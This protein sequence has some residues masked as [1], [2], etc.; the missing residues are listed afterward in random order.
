[1]LGL[2]LW[3]VLCVGGG[4]LV[5]VVTQGGDSLWYASLNKPTWTP[6]SRVFAPVWTTLYAAMGLAAWLVWRQGG[7]SRQS[8]PLTVFFAQLT[9]N[10]AWS[11]IFFGLQ[12]IV[13]ALIDIFTLWTLIA[14][15]IRVFTRVNRA[16]AWLLAPYLAWVSFATALNA[17]I[18][19]MN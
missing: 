11:F 16:A 4:A 10:F 13:W 2:V 6:P 17:A 7:W 15:T 14:V 5:G 9:L 18:V 8:M 1:L 19:W 12:Q 3:V